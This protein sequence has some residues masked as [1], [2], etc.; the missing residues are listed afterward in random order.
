MG[1]MVLLVA[2]ALAVAGVALATPQVIVD[3]DFGLP[4]RPFSDVNAERGN[5]LTGSL[6]EGWA[7]NSGWKSGSPP[8]RV[9]PPPE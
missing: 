4:G 3:T 8:E 1:R 7:E 5:R 9:A 2:V 6:P